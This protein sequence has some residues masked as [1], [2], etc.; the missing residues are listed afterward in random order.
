MS[1]LNTLLPVVGFSVFLG[2]NVWLAVVQKVRTAKSLLKQSS[3]ST[4]MDVHNGYNLFVW[5]S[6]HVTSFPLQA[7][8]KIN[9]NG[10]KL[11]LMLIS[12]FHQVF[13]LALK[14]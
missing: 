8:M 6:P 7:N 11:F 12:S 9:Q 3:L 4:N 13:R 1:L 2:G 10:E 14:S 5:L